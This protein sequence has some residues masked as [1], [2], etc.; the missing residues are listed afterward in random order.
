MLQKKWNIKFKTNGCSKIFDKIWPIV[1]SL[2]KGEQ[3][4]WK[5]H[6]V[7]TTRFSFGKRASRGT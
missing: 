5:F 6:H 3:D 7:E 2:W 1:E 4:L